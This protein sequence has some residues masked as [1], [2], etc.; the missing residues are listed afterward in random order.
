[1]TNSEIGDSHL[2]TPFL[3]RRLNMMR[4]KGTLFGRTFWSRGYC[5]STVGMDEERIR[6]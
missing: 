1:M 4:T 2:F 6:R 3:F 5:V